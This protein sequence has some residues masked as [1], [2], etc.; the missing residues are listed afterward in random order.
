MLAESKLADM[1]GRM[2]V[3]SL[4]VIPPFQI[5]HNSGGMHRCPGSSVPSAQGG[6]ADWLTVNAQCATGRK[7]RALLSGGIIALEETA[8]KPG[9]SVDTGGPVAYRNSA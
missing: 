7:Q 6:Q 1:T 4:P 3:T 8:T 2:A 9:N 5:H